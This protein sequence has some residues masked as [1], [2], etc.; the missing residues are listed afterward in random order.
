MIPCEIHTLDTVQLSPLSEKVTAKLEVIER[1]KNVQ[2]KW[3]AS[4]QGR[5][6]IARTFSPAE[7]TL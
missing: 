4:M 1:K 3:R 7:G 2:R 5:D 6:K